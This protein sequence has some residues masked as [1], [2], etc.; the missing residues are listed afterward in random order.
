MDMMQT[1]EPDYSV[2]IPPEP[3]PITDFVEKTEAACRTA[4]DLHL[5]DKAPTEAEREAAANALFA[6]AEAEDPVEISQKLAK[7]QFT[8]AIYK[9]AKVLLD[10]YGVRVVE[11]ANQLRLLVTNKLLLLTDNEDVKVQLRALELLGKFTDVGLFTEKSEV[12]INHRSTN[13]L[14]VSLREKIQKMMYPEGIREAEVIDVKP[15]EINGEVIDSP[16]D[17][18]PVK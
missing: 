9:E 8:P 18:D 1:L 13:D 15:V 3:T 11:N 17:D 6:L 2:P 12:T 5:A 4:E 10:N 14:V 16:F 7:K